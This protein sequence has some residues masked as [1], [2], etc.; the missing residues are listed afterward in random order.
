MNDMNRLNYLDDSLVAVAQQ[1][2]Q[3]SKNKSITQENIK[4]NGSLYPGKTKKI[5]SFRTAAIASMVAITLVGLH[6][7]ANYEMLGDYKKATNEIVQEQLPETYD[8]LNYQNYQNI[9]NNQ[10]SFIEEYKQNQEVLTQIKEEK[11]ELK[12][13]G[14]YGFFDGARLKDDAIQNV[15]LENTLNSIEEAQNYYEEGANSY[16]K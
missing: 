5:I 11:Q 8:Q 9:V 2:Y 12:Q 13:T 15:A 16:G 7:Y 4:V 6:D 1:K 14:D 10:N 3:E